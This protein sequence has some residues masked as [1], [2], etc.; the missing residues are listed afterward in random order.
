[1]NDC[2]R[3][4]I[5]SSPIALSNVFIP[6]TTS[7]PVLVLRMSLG[8][9]T[10]GILRIFMEQHAMIHFLTLKVLP[11]CAIAAEPKPVSETEALAFSTVRKWRK[12]F[13]ERRTSL[14]DD[15]RSGRTL[16]TT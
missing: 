11:T 10:F 6:P 5:S 14:Y 4:I 9:C 2:I 16:P 8:V 12:R 7:A 13:T 3:Q 1:M 15:P